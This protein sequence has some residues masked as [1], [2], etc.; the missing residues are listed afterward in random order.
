[1]DDE[2]AGPV[3]GEAIDDDLR[4]TLA[5]QMARLN[6]NL[7]RQFGLIEDQQAGE[8]KAA[9]RRWRIVMA[10]VVLIA[11]GNIRVEQ[12]RRDGDRRDKRTAAA[13]ERKD[14]AAAAEAKLTTCRRTNLSRA[15]IRGAFA[16]Q[17]EALVS[18]ANEDQK[19]VA[20]AL[21]QDTLDRLATTLKSTPCSDEPAADYESCA[22]AVADGVAPLRRGQPGYRAELDADGDGIAC[23]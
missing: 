3:P 16:Q 2:Q 20:A 6:D 12:V 1:M 4:G 9:R 8:R 17:G 13:Q 18:I 7:E 19:A 15:E 5:T 22:E 11:L 21:V 14:E 23:E 10:V